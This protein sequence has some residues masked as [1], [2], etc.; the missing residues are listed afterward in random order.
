M[1]QTSKIAVKKIDFT[2]CECEVILLQNATQSRSL[3]VFYSSRS[4][5]SLLESACL[6][7]ELDTGA[8]KDYFKVVGT[9][10][11]WLGSKGSCTA[12]V[13][14]VEAHLLGVCQLSWK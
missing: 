4:P 3:E 2:L 14:L 1:K 7:Y 11:T 6:K 12:L 5:C 10:G 13:A 8:I 9:S